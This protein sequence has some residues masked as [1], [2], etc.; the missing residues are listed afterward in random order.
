[1]ILAIAAAVCDVTQQ[2][3]LG[4]DVVAEIQQQQLGTLKTGKKRKSTETAV[5]CPLCHQPVEK[6]RLQGMFVIMCYI[7]V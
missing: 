3:L 1:M 7:L 5:N 2:E 6:H 4:E